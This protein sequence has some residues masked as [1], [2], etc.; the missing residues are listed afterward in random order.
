MI[1]NSTLNAV[2]L[3]DY[4]KIHNSCTAYIVLLGICF[5]ISTSISSVSIYFHWYLKRRYTETTIY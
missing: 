3:N 5:I 4:R 2:P 1:Y